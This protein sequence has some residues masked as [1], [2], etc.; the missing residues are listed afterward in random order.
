[1]IDRPKR[2][3]PVPALRSIDGPVLEL[4]R[5]TLRGE[6]SRARGLF[7]PSYLDRLFRSPNRHR[8]R[9][10][11]NLLWQLALLELW[12]QTHETPRRELRSDSVLH[13]L[14]SA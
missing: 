9:G 14:T 13:Q 10:G 5:Q 7:Q 11:A 1:V 4:A 8:S 3:F 12:L 2:Y 6:R